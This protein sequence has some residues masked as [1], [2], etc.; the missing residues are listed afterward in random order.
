MLSY[1]QLQSAL[2]NY[3]QAGHQLQVKLT[4]NQAALQAE[5]N[6]IRQETVEDFAAKVS[7]KSEVETL[8]EQLQA[9]NLR[10]QELEAEVAELKQ[11]KVEEPQPETEEEE[12]QE[13]Q[14]NWDAFWESAE[15]N[16]EEKGVDK[17]Q[18]LDMNSDLLF[19]VMQKLRNEGKKATLLWLRKE[20]VKYHS[21]TCSQHGNSFNIW[22]WQGFMNILEL[23]KNDDLDY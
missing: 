3:R 14:V 7:E 4:A 12:E 22:Q 17:K 18:A 10:I 2:K 8:K 20:S 16:T 5:Y 11:P 21:D 1:R 13:Q 6:R 19:T 9:A 23:V 15:A